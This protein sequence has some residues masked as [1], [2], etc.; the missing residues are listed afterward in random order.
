V[1]ALGIY[2]AVWLPTAVRP[3]VEH[4]T[5]SQLFQTSPD[6]NFYV[7]SLRWWPYAIGHV[8]NPLYST[9]LE[10][11][12]GHALAWAATSPALGLL[13][14]PLTMAA[15][16][17]ASLNVLTVLALPVSAWAAFV[18]C[19]RLT[20]KFWPALVGG[21]V[22]GF[23]AYEMNHYGAGQINLACT[24]L[25]PILAYLALLWRDES[26]SSATF[27]VL[28]GVTIA[29][30]FYL[31]L[32]TFADLT[33]ILAIS[34][35]LG[36]ALAGR[37]RRPAL[38]SLARLVGIAYLIA[39]VLA[40][41]YIWYALTT[42]PPKPA[43]MK[44]LD[45]ASLVVPNS[46]RTFGIGWLA[47]AAAGPHLE[48]HGGYVGVPLLILAILLAVTA[49]SSRLVRLLSCVL[50]LIVVAS[51]GPELYLE[52]HPIAR[53]PWAGLYGLPI[54]RSAYPT[55]LMLFAFLGL[56]VAAALWLADRATR[57]RW[58]RWILAAC[59]VAA[60][61]LNATGITVTRQTTVPA[62]ISSGQ[63]RTDLSPG[64]IVVVV[65]NVRNAGMLWQAESDFYM[66]ISGGFLNAGYSHRV[67]WPTPVQ[68]LVR[69]TPVSVVNFENFVRADHV[70]AILLDVRYK[71]RWVGIF[72]KIGL[73]GHTAGN[74]IV[75]PT[76]GCRSCR[77]LTGP[78]IR[79]KLRVTA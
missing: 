71:P 44:S 15:G 69:A 53:I 35:G 62:F 74:V 38:L 9:Q 57:W 29:A 25:L 64:E 3:L 27:V 1:L 7:W 23:S 37:E 65:S 78:E 36:A 28:A 63:Y 21:A 31:F 76:D 70:G 5:R 41:P 33:A 49:W 8:L 6:P 16:P 68:G 61:A 48:S 79:Q 34:L 17:V 51:L 52:G 58:A 13:A 59:V 18:L 72:A 22:F 26:I 67:D 24:L 20:G 4:L 12:A 56:A 2:L 40:T 54:V 77:V 42:A 19:R 30:Q 10:A 45:L 50:V 55:R 46:E 43:T 60:L 73:L 66:R 11:P 14:A 32:E 39:M 47:R 75:Y